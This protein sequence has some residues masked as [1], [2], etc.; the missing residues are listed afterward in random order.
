MNNIIFDVEGIVSYPNF[1]SKIIQPLEEQGTNILFWTYSPQLN[2]F[3]K[4]RQFGLSRYAEPGK[5]IGD[6]IYGALSKKVEDTDLATVLQQVGL[7]YNDISLDRL[8]KR[9]GE[10]EALR[11]E[12]HI[13]VGCKY[14][15]L[16]GNDSYLLFESDCSLYDSSNWY[17]QLA[18]EDTFPDADKRLA[19]EAGYSVII[20]PEHPDVWLAGE[21]KVLPEMVV[22]EMHLLTTSWRGEQIVTDLRENINIYQ[23]GRQRSVERW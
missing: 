11:K 20:V 14:P 17:S 22:Q 4:L 6:E 10:Y 9:Y 23:E 15:P 8:R 5:C 19:K 7:P 18:I 16:L 3:N 12:L 21:G 1:E 2:G 13:H